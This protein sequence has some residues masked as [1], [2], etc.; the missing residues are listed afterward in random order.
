[1]AYKNLGQSHQT[2]YLYKKETAVWS[3]DMV[4]KTGSRLTLQLVSGLAI[5]QQ[6]EVTRNVLQKYLFYERER[7]KGGGGR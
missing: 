7:F 3:C 5:L 1:L 6:G 2:K 4:A